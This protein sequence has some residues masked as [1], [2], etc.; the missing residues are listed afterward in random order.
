VWGLLVGLLWLPAVSLAHTYASDGPIRVLLHTDPDDNPPTH[1]P[2][3]LDFSVF[4]D[5]NQFLGSRCNCAV[6]VTG[7]G[8][9]ILKQAIFTGKDADKNVT[10]VPVIFPQL[11]TYTVNIAGQPKPGSDFHA[12]NLNYKVPVNTEGSAGG[13]AVGAS[14]ILANGLKLVGIYALAAIIIVAVVVMSAR[15]GR[16][17]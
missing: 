14:S 9:T 13:A 17:K 11:G 8:K 2:T 15:S 6:T 5:T 7:N 4:D 16:K 10:T 1:N 3:Q 12:F